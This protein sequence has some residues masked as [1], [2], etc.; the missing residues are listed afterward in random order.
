MLNFDG[1]ESVEYA[2]GGGNNPTLACKVVAGGLRN[3]V[4]FWRVMGASNFVQKVIVEGWALSFTRSPMRR[5]LHYHSSTKQ[6]ADFVSDSVCDLVA[7]GCARRVVDGQAY[8]CSPL[9][10][11]NNGIN[12]R[13]ILDLRYVHKCRAQNKFKMMDLKTVARVY[14]KGDSFV[15]FDL[16]SGYHHIAIAAEYHKYLWL[17]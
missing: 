13:L 7:R 9:G 1:G 16:K 4:E 10:V 12:L 17:P 14:E 5:M 8:G 6:H 2:R 11:C 3:C 15:T